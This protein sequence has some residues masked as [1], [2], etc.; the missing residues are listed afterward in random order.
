MPTYTFKD[1]STGEVFD[2]FMRISE[3]EDYLAE[4]PHLEPVLS[5]SGIVHEVGTNLKVADVFRDKIK[6][7][8]SRYR[9]NN[10]KDY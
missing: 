5:Y 3:R 9:V 8:K 2:K 10:I 4:N 7:I 6:Q 1:T